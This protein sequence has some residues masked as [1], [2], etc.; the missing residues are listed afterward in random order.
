MDKIYTVTIS[1]Y[2]DDFEQ[3]EEVKNYLLSQFEKEYN[4]IDYQGPDLYEEK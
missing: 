3:A 2:A 4:Y 1:F